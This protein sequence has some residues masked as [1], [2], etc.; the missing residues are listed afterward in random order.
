MI[1]TEE[2]NGEN[3]DLRTEFPLHTSK[4]RIYRSQQYKHHIVKAAFSCPIFVLLLRSFWVFCL[5]GRK[6]DIQDRDDWMWTKNVGH[7]HYFQLVHL[8]VW[9]RDRAIRPRGGWWRSWFC[10]HLKHW[11]KDINYRT[12]DT[13][14]VL[15]ADYRTY[16]S[17]LAGAV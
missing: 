17:P 16:T 9:S 5:T 4:R 1:W 8:W 11:N 12:K 15:M 13:I 10:F 6:I 7:K 2:A 14:L 3:A